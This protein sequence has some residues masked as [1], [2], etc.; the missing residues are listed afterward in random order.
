MTDSL[1]YDALD[2]G[3]RDVVRLIREAGYETT[4]SGDGISK[5]ATQPDALPFPHV[6][7]RLGLVDWRRS[8]YH[9]HDL[10][11]DRFGNEW[12]VQLSWAPGEPAIVMVMGPEVTP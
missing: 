4:D 12:R 7:V 1:D 9:L 8:T 2:P 11:R 10:V 6:V 3:I 5:R